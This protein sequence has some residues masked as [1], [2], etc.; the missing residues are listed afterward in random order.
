MLTDD[1]P[2]AYQVTRMIGTS[3]PG[4]KHRQQQLQYT[5]SLPRIYRDC[6]TRPTPTAMVAEKKSPIFPSSIPVCGVDPSCMD[7]G[8]AGLVLR[9]HFCLKLNQKPKQVQPSHSD[10]ADTYCT[11]F[12]LKVNEPQKAEL[13]KRQS[14]DR[15]SP[16]SYFQLAA[17]F[18]A[19]R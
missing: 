13:W 7:D 14:S 3:H 4:R 18:R 15:G 12:Q 6:I 9:P 8:W 19:R 10:R 17:G 1:T 11:Y 5:S 2:V 16:I